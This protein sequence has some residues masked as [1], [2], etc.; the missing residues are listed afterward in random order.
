MQESATLRR[1]ELIEEVKRYRQT[2]VS[3]GTRRPQSA[4]LQTGRNGHSH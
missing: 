1:G 4:V 2:V 3:A